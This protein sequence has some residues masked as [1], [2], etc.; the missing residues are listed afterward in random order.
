MNSYSSTATSYAQQFPL[1]STEEKAGELS[2]SF[3]A[4]MASHGP[5]PYLIDAFICACTCATGLIDMRR[6][7]QIE[8]E[9]EK[10]LPLH[11][12]QMN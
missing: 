11:R 2:E 12:V 10:R 6:Y 1:L 9:L 5:V 4:L 3:F 7:R 8:L